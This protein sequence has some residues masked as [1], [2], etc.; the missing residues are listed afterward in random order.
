MSLSFPSSP[1]I[2]QIVVTGNQSWRWDGVKW[3]LVSSVGFQGSLGFTGSLGFGGFQGSSGFQGSVGYQGSSGVGSYQGSVGYAGSAGFGSFQGSVGFQGSQSAGG[4]VGSIGFRGS[5]GDIGFQGSSSYGGFVGSRG[6]TGYQSSLGFQGSVGFLGS[7]NI[8][9]Q[10]STGFQSSLGF[11]G[12]V[13]FQGSWGFQGSI[14]QA[15]V[16]FGD[17]PPS[18]P[19]TGLLWFDTNNAIL[20]AWYQSANNWIGING[21]TNGPTGFTGSTGSRGY[22]GSIGFTGSSGPSSLPISNQTAIYVPTVSDIGKLISSNSNIVINTGVFSL[23]HT[24]TIFNN[25]T[26]NTTISP[27]TN[28]TIIWA[29]VANTG[30]RLLL[31]YG[32]ASLICVNSTS[33]TFVISG[34]LL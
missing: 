12:S 17:T 13:G 28:V 11:Q 29:G 21:G 31:P 10:G 2:G 15:N 22:D 33:N 26:A 19:N 16:V 9:Y 4:Y 7:V 24:F 25:S 18:N 6:A 27:N 20:A 23:G 32:L 30:P 1:S 14:G 8:G 5:V 3:S 34:N